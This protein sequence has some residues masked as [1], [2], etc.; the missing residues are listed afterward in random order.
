LPFVNNNIAWVNGFVNLFFKKDEAAWMRA[1]HAA[2]MWQQSVRA[3]L[4]A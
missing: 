4:A 3:V 1:V 2:S